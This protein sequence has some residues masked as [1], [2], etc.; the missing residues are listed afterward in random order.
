MNARGAAAEQQESIVVG[1]SA[2]IRN[3]RCKKPIRG[4]RDLQSNQYGLRTSHI[5][6]VSQ[7]K[8][9]WAGEEIPQL[10]FFGGLYI[11][12]GPGYDEL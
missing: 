9:N 5:I 1:A 10:F 3:W 2:T 7:I 4:Q 6:P 12:S 8:V 11:N